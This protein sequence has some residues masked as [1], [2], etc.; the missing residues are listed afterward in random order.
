VI[1]AAVTVGKIATGEIDG[2]TAESIEPV[3]DV[4]HKQSG[5]SWKIIRYMS[6]ER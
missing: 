2:S 4:F 1:G 5:G 3:I 6:Y